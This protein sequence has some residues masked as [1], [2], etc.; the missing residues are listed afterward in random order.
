M[1]RYSLELDLLFEEGVFIL[2]EG[3]TLLFLR[4]SRLLVWILVT[5]EL[6]IWIDDCPNGG[7]L[8]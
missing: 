8:V 3:A 7:C 6:G 1:V 4:R 2:K 5:W